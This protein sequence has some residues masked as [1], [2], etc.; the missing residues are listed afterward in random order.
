MYTTALESGAIW[1]L[2]YVCHRPWMEPHRLPPLLQ[3]TQRKVNHSKFSQLLLRIFRYIFWLALWIVPHLT[4]FQYISE[5]A[6]DCANKALKLL[7]PD[8]Q[9]QCESSRLRN[10]PDGR[11]VWKAR[12]GAERLSIS[13]GNRDYFYQRPKSF[14][15]WLNRTDWPIGMSWIRISYA[16]FMLTAYANKISNTANPLLC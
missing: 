2:R 7:Y 12:R 1:R 11:Q 15:A 6:C 16:W 4:H 3:N 5:N 10:T 13:S 14:L 8:Y 9:R